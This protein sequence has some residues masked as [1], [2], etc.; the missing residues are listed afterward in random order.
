VQRSPDGVD[1]EILVSSILRSGGFTVNTRVLTIRQG[2]VVT[3][4][5]HPPRILFYTELDLEQGYAYN[6]NFYVNPQLRHRGI[7]ARL[8]SLHEEICREAGLTIL[9]NDNRNPEF[10]KRQGY[11]RLNPFR[12]MRLARRLGIEFREQ[13]MYKVC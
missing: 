6:E 3:V 10:W 7:G 13:S 2:P 11:R 12:Q 8:S 1:I 5:F 9:I 4:D